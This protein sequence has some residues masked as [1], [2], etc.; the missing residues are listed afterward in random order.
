[1]GQRNKMKRKPVGA[2]FRPRCISGRRYRPFPLTR[3]FPD[4]RVTTRFGLR[5]GKLLWT[6]LLMFGPG[7][8]YKGGPRHTQLLYTPRLSSSLVFKTHH[9]FTSPL[10]HQPTSNPNGAF[11]LHKFQQFEL[12]LT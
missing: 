11:I 8:L 7:A 1:M 5:L 4:S 6:D 9:Y 10:H 12:A 2:L 3:H